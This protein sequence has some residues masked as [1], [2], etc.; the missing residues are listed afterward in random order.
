MEDEANV[1]NMSNEYNVA[2]SNV[3]L[4]NSLQEVNV[5]KEIEQPKEVMVGELKLPTYRKVLNVMG[6]GTKKTIPILTK[7]E[8]A[9]IMGVRMQ[10]LAGGAKPCVDTRGMKSIEDIAKAELERR[11]LPFLIKRPLPNG[12]CEY[13]KLEEFISV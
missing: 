9:R 12:T 5:D 13:W 10:Q 11:V 4:G 8:K 6:K 2:A 7:Y 1:A 3:D